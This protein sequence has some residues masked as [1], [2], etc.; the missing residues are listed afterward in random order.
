MKVTYVDLENFLQLLIRYCSPDVVTELN[1]RTKYNVHFYHNV[2]ERARPFFRKLEKLDVWN[3]DIFFLHMQD[4]TNLISLTLR[5][6]D[7]PNFFSP[8]ELNSIRKLCLYNV[9]E[10][11]SSDEKLKGL[12]NIFPNLETFA[13][14]VEKYDVIE[15]VGKVLVEKCSNLRVLVISIFF[16][17]IHERC[18]CYKI[19]HRF[20][21]LQKLKS[22][23]EIKIVGNVWNLQNIY[24]LVQFTP[25]IRKLDIKDLPCLISQPNQLVRSIREAIANRLDRFPANDCVHLIV[26]PTLRS[27]FNA[28]KNIDEI[29]R[30]TIGELDPSE[31]SDEFGSLLTRK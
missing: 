9:R 17:A 12:L 1:F 18:K 27:Y 14:S 13:C 16:K 20:Q 8:I 19:V 6:W 21:F 30:F 24:K 26:N 3:G 28:V 15:D 4:M 31:D 29:I 11:Y 5:R 22:L 7:P 2:N 25:N 23:E 10:F